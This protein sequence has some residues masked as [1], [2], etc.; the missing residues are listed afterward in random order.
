[1]HNPHGAHVAILGLTKVINHYIETSDSAVIVLRLLKIYTMELQGSPP[2]LGTSH[3][4]GVRT[5]ESSFVAPP[6]VN[7]A[8]VLQHKSTT[9]VLVAT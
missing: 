2:H 1:M 3:H 6:T 5:R 7:S 4:S 9:V 8:N